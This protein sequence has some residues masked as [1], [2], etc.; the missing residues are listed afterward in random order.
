MDDLPPPIIVDIL[1][2]L[3]DS[4]D[5]ARCRVVCRSLNALSRDVRS[6]NLHCTL[7]RYN[8]SRSREDRALTKPFKAIFY[9]LVR[10]S[11]VLESVAI[12]VEKSLNGISYDDVDDES[13]DLFLTDVRFVKEWLPR[14]CGELK[15]LSISDFWVQSCWRRSD[16]LALISSCCTGLLSLELK[17]AWLSVDGLNPMPKLTSLTLEFIRLDD[18]DLNRVNH[19]FPCLQV[20]NLIGVGGFKEPKIHLCHLKKC[21]WTVSNAPHSLTIFAPKLMKLKLKCIRPE[22]LVLDTPLLSDFHLSIEKANKL[23][24]KEFL[25]LKSLKLDSVNLCSLIRSFPSGTKLRKLTLDSSKLIQ[26]VEMTRLSLEAL[27]DAFPSLS[28]ITVCKL[29]WSEMEMCFLT[30]GIQS[31]IEMRSLKEITAQLV[32][33]DVNVTLMFIF[34]ILDKCTNLADITFLIHHEVEANVTGNLISKCTAYRP[35]VNW[36]WGICK[37]GTG[38]TWV[39]HGI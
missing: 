5:L 6:I 14:V 8:R 12:G 27:F 31:Q 24:V 25:D 36:R 30:S 29:A 21:Q 16:I 32:I 13:D 39:C 28:S 37:E 11:R 23:G 35:G 7:S 17:N 38:D 33:C 34:S 4:A 10:D 3:T 18:E 22:S 9:D 15:S 20:L 26:P 19:G 2:R 1:S